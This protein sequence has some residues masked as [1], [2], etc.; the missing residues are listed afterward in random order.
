MEMFREKSRIETYFMFLVIP[1]N[2]TQ[3]KTHKNKYS[4]TFEYYFPRDE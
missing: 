4:L 3:S 2:K 1:L